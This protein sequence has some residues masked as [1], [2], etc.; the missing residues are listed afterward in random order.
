MPVRRPRTPWRMQSRGRPGRSRA[1]HWSWSAFGLFA[2]VRELRI[3]EMG[4]GLAVAVLIDT[5]ILR[6]VLLPATMKLLGEWNWYL[7]R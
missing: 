6:A 2:S 1:R 3:K 5:T 4:F 7:P